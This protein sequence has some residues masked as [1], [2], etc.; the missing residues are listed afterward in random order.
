MRS[1]TL[2]KRTKLVKKKTKLELFIGLKFIINVLTNPHV[3]SSI[4]YD[5]NNAVVNV[6]LQTLVPS[7]S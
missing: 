1:V 4:Q 2:I 6:N 3:M 7:F 5:V